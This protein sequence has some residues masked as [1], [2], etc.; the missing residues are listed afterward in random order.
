MSI[1]ES[2]IQLPSFTVQEMSVTVSRVESNWSPTYHRSLFQVITDV[3]NGIKN[4][5]GMQCIYIHVHGVER[6]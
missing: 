5:T 6:G 2:N 3:W 4:I 1:E